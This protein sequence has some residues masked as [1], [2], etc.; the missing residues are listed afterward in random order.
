MYN[1]KVGVAPTIDRVV[2]SHKLIATLANYNASVALTI[3]RIVKLCKVHTANC[4]FKS[5]RKLLSRP[6]E[7]VRLEPDQH[8]ALSY[9]IRQ[10]N[11]MGN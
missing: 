8:F 7:P 3:D 11:F 5:N 2:K 10:E 6:A 1:Y 4:S 9:T